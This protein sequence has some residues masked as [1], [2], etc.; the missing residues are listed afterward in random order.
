MTRPFCAWCERPFTP[1]RTGGK[2]QRFCRGACRRAFE[3]ELRAWARD[4]ITAGDVTQAQLQ[5]ARSVGAPT[6]GSGAPSSREQRA[7]PRSKARVVL[8]AFMS[9]AV[10]QA[11][12]INQTRSPPRGTGLAGLD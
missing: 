6:L 1:R 2:P 3:R 9:R 11:Q 10:V 7:L 8:R 12:E 4:Q 5:R